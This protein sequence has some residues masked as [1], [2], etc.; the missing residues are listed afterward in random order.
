MSNVKPNTILVIG[1]TGK[2]GSRVF[3]GL[4]KQGWPVRSGSRSADPGF[5]WMAPHTW[6]AALEG[7]HAVYITFQPDISVPGALDIIQAFTRVAVTAGVKKLVLLSGRGEQEAEAAEQVIIQS[8][9]NWVVIRASWFCQNFSEGYLLPPV[10]A[11]FVA[12]PAGNVGE[13]FVDV[14]DIAAVAMA[15]LTDDK[16]NGQVYELTGPRLLTFD[17]AVTEIGQAAG[18][19]VQYQEVPMEAYKA[20]MKE[21]EVPEDVIDLLHYLFV[22]VLDGRN[23]KVC[24]GVQ[25]ALGR[26][27]TDFS[28]YA[29]KAA[30]TG[31]WN[32]NT[33]VAES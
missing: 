8:G 22:E 1:A 25:R 15:A 11:G 26:P 21:H 28:D 32:V 31:I 5:D 9:L 19:P 17:Q 16:H 24:D 7:V 3:N 2:T 30:A 20:V 12:L 23:E 4:E 27:A 14:D 6:E 13:P 18:R 29:R 33:T 10:L